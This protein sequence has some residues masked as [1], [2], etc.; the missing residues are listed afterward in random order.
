VIQHKSYPAQFKAL[1]DEQEQGIFEAVVSVFDNVDKVNDRVIKGAF[2]DSLKAWAESGDPIPVIWNHEWDDLDAHV[3]KV[4]EAKE[5]DQGL[6]IKGQMDLEEDFARRLFRKL[7]ERRIKEFSFGYEIKER[8]FVE[9][10]GRTVNELRVLDLFEVGPTLKGANPDTQLLGVKADES[11]DESTAV[12][13]TGGYVHGP[14]AAASDSIPAL[15]SDGAHVLP[16]AQL[17]GFKAGRTLSAKNEKL[18]RDAHEAIGAVLAALDPPE[19]EPAKSLAKAEEP[20]ESGAKAEEPTT[21][22]RSPFGVLSEVD[23]DLLEL[24]A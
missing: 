5:I 7:K 16:A 6:W 11:T 20:S 22:S 21:R 1:D 10:D 2:A 18:L 19:D 12:R 15:L 24:G 14:G 23:T 9:E 13:A 8:A 3:G 17:Q 4:L